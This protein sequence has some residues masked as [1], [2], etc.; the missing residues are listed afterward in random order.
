MNVRL[1]KVLPLVA[2]ISLILFADIFAQSLLSEVRV[3]PQASVTQ[4]VG[5]ATVEINY[6][7]PGVKGREIWGKLVPYDL[8][9]EKTFI[10]EKPMPWR[11]G[12]DENTTITLSHD[13]KINGS[14]LAAGTYGMHMI[15]SKDEWTI[16][17][18]KDK[19]AWGSYFYND[20]HDVLRIKAKPE[21][22]PFQE[23][24]VFGFDKLT[25]GSCEA[26]LQWEK[27][28]VPFNIEFD[29]NKIV[30]DSYTEELTGE[31]G[32]YSNS[33]RDAA[34]Y[35]LDNNVSLDLALVW[36]ENAYKAARPEK[37][38]IDVLK[39]GL[40]KV[41][42]KQDEGNELLNDAMKTATEEDLTRYGRRLLGANNLDEVIKV[43][44]TTVKKYP[45]SWRAYY[46]CGVAYEGKGE[47][48]NA[49]TNYKKAIELAP[50][51][52]KTRIE[53][54]LNSL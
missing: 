48:D 35:C 45:G 38:S 5:L 31:A 44:Q 34:Q 39:A 17:F 13:A 43:M 26:F 21:E 30:V 20:A 23:W 46:Y 16:I 41:T 19:K 15:V 52:I 32:F 11:A 9:G 49:K 24:M 2:L 22:A 12:A 1:L 6:S 10:E 4:Y 29:K 8:A 14:P 18:S 28:K 27:I 54:R 51:A 42:G 25:S 7:R 33:W 40:L 50:E 47:K 53:G 37:F 36:V 3:S